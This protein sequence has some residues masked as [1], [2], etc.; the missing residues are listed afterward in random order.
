MFIV[1]F[2]LQSIFFFVIN[3]NLMSLCTSC[4]ILLSPLLSFSFPEL[5][6]Y[7]YKLVFIFLVLQQESLTLNYNSTLFLLSYL[8]FP[9]FV[10]RNLIKLISCNIIDRQKICS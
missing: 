4:C 6:Y 9:I 3:H 10:L 8:S 1:F 2:F 5:D 7:S